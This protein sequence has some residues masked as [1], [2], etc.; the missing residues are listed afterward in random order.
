M[1]LFL[2]RNIELVVFEVVFDW[3]ILNKSISSEKEKAMFKKQNYFTLKQNINLFD[4]K[5][6]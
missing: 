1:C 6:D 4:I 3:T 5:L 2:H